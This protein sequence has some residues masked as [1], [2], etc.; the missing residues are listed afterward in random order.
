MGD[1]TTIVRKSDVVLRRAVEARSGAQAKKP[2][3][4]K[5]P[6]SG[7]V[8]PT[9]TTKRPPIVQT[10]LVDRSGD[11]VVVHTQGKRLVVV[12]GAAGEKGRKSTKTYARPQLASLALQRLI[13]SLRTK[14]Y[15]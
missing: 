6:K 8:A 9:P 15:R 4:K 7:S 5:T 11:F 13:A 14:G 3:P 2:T 1:A 10:R 12:R